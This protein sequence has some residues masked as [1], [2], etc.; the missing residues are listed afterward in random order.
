VSTSEGL[1]QDKVAVVT[2]GGRGIGRAVAEGMAAQGAKVAVIS[3]T[4][5]ELHEVVDGITG[6]NGEA[7]AVTADVTK[8]DQVQ[9]AM[10]TILSSFG[11]IDI[12]VNNAGTNLALGL[13]WEVD[14]VDWWTDVETSLLGPFL[15]TQV[16]GAAMVERGSGRIINISSGAATEPR[17]YSSGYAAAK[18]AAQ[19]YSESVAP[20]FLER[21]VRVFSLNPGPVKTTLNDQARNSDTGRRFAQAPMSRYGEATRVA[22]H[23][24]FLASGK[25]DALAGRYLSVFEELEDVVR[26]DRLADPEFLTLRVQGWTWA[27]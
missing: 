5:Q 13:P 11:Q 10:S 2:G 24:I 22:D 1:L 27:R 15:C 3:R 9:M 7:Q 8:P 12:L 16:V 14:P 18:T 26:D 23:A 25:G 17:P 6:K 20:L 19:R 4:D 21:G